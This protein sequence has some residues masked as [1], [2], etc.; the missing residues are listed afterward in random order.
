MSRTARAHWAGR[1]E[2][3][4]QVSTSLRGA[5]AAVSDVTAATKLGTVTV[6]VDADG[7]FRSITV[8]QALRREADPE[9]L[10]SLVLQLIAEAHV[11]R[12]NQ[13][14]EAAGE[15]LDTPAPP[16]SVP[17]VVAV[18]QRAIKLRGAAGDHAIDDAI[19]EVGGLAGALDELIEE[20]RAVADAHHVGRST[21][22]HATAV[23]SGRSELVSLELDE[24]WLESAHHFNIGREATEA[25]LA[26]LTLAARTSLESVVASSRLGR[27][28]AALTEPDHINGTTTEGERG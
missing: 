11:T 4:L 25:A 18:E 3:G 6:T 12:L 23:A 8:G 20:M 10:G 16:G 14:A 26:A 13:W 15:E 9:S 17:P 5:V 21:G 7:G 2:E 27:L 24:R 28:R 22:R 1:Q 19:R